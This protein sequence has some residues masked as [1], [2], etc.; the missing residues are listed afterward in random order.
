MSKSTPTFLL[1]LLE[2]GYVAY[3]G[4]YLSH[5][6]WTGKLTSIWDV[7]FLG[8]PI[9][10]LYSME[11]EQYSFPFEPVLSQDSLMTSHRIL[12]LK[13][14]LETQHSILIL[15][16]ASQGPLRDCDTLQVTA[17]W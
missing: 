1:L 5:P 11:C 15:Q 2:K 10:S 12:E 8:Q 7:Q 3:F 17:S 4:N 16:R 6:Q 14:H 9:L 13:E